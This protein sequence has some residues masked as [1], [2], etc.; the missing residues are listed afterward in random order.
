M[1]PNADIVAD[2]FHVMQMVNRELN[3]ARN[4]L[5]KKNE[6][7]QNKVEKERVWA[8]LKLSKYI[9]L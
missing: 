7:N 5:I 6:S 3:T 9:W 4:T 8:A 2:R 1:M